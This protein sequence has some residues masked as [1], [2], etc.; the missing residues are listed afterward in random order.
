MA[1]APHGTVDV[2]DDA[3]DDVEWTEES[4]ESS[5]AVSV[6]DSDE[7]VFALAPYSM[8][9]CHACISCDALSFPL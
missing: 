2:D 7:S 4:A 5:Y 6:D 1:V 9:L 8:V 3:Y